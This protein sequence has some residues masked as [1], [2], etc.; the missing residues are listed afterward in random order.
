MNKFD[1][2]KFGSF[3]K[4][5]EQTHNVLVNRFF[6]S[7]RGIYEQISLNDI[8]NDHPDI[9]KQYTDIIDFE[10]FVFKYFGYRF[11]EN[12]SEFFYVK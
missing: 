2:D 6:T 9:Y 4:Y 3:E 5:L 11:N 1:I 12:S 8:K 7:C 10:N